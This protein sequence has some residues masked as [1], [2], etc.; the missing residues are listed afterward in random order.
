MRGWSASER[1]NMITDGAT[2]EVVALAAV[3]GDPK[4]SKAHLDRAIQHVRKRLG[5]G[6]G[7]TAANAPC[8]RS[9]RWPSRRYEEAY[10]LAIARR[11]DLERPATACSL[12]VWPRCVCKRWE[13]ATSRPSRR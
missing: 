5:A 13:A 4:L 1:H 7:S 2:D 3:L 12:P 6:K 10:E 8:A 9:T 11:N